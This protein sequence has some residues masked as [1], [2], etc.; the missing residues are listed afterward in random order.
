MECYVCQTFEI[1]QTRSTKFIFSA[2]FIVCLQS[3][4]IASLKVFS[5][6]VFLLSGKVRRLPYETLMQRLCTEIAF[7]LM[8]IY[9]VAFPPDSQDNSHIVLYLVVKWI[10]QSLN[11]TGFPSWRCLLE[12]GWEGCKL[13]SN[14]Q[15]HK[16]LQLSEM[17]ASCQSPN[18]DHV[19]VEVM[20]WL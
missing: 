5:P 16:S 10:M 4:N 20:W 8:V 1:V 14:D 15:N 2:T 18:C 12:T 6:P 3:Q 9:S 11:K 17:W 13:Q 19:T 7:C